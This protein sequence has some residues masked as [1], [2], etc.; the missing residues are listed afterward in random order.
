M[1]DFDKKIVLIH[2]PRCGG[3][4]IEDVLHGSSYFRYAPWL[5][6]RSEKEYQRIIRLRGELPTEYA[7]YGLIR[8]PVARMQSMFSRGYWHESVVFPHGIEKHLNGVGFSRFLALVKPASHEGGN[9]KLI[10]Y[11]DGDMIT[12]I[13]DLS[14]IG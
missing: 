1:I 4:S 2:P 5:K 8:E 13:H 11:F 7:F 6:H 9:L 3:S 12:Q 10:D 14:A